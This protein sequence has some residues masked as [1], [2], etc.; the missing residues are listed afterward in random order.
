MKTILLFAL[1]ILLTA[2]SQATDYCVT[3]FDNTVDPTYYAQINFW[4]LESISPG[5]FET[6]DYI[7]TKITETYT[8]WPAFVVFWGDSGSAMSS[9][10]SYSTQYANALAWGQLI[11]WPNYYL[12]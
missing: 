10:G 9:L 3:G 2:T 11:Y 5:V 4:R 8:S 6:G 12:M 1:T 7:G